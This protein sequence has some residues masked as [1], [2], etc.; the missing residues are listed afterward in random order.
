MFGIVAGLG[1]RAT[2]EF[3]SAFMDKVTQETQGC[4]PRLIMYNV[5][6]SP[7]IE[8]AFLQ[9]AVDDAA[10]PRQKVRD[11]LNQAVQ[12]FLNNQVTTVAMACNTLQDELTRL[13]KINGL[14]NLN[15]I[16]ATADAIRQRNARKVLVLGTASTYSDDLYGQ[17]LNEHGIKCIY[18][19]ASQQDF[20]ETYIRFALDQN[21]GDTAKQQFDKNIKNIAEATGADSVVLACT[22]LTGDLDEN[23]SELMVFDSLQ[24]LAQA[25]ATHVLNRGELFV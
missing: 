24:L 25:S 4:L 19:N 13:C 15:M 20:I 2:V 7:A 12:H 18:P 9:G 11:L 10:E 14:I 6:M 1:P 23:D 3:Y 16:D 8:N 5:A 21:I 17:R 22:D